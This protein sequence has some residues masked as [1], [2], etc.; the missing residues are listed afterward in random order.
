MC[1]EIHLKGGS[2]ML[3]AGISLPWIQ[4]KALH[5][6][7]GLLYYIVLLKQHHQRDLYKGAFAQADSFRGVTAHHCRELWHTMVGAHTRFCCSLGRTMASRDAG[8]S[9]GVGRESDVPSVLRQRL[10]CCS[11]LPLMEVQSSP[12]HLPTPPPLNSWAFIGKR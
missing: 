12:W 1:Q 3:D 10:E 4:M 5:R 6:K 9:L 2:Q 7:G 11:L 8:K